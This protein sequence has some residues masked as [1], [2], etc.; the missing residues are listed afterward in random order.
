LDLSK[1]IA[2]FKVIAH[3]GANR[4]ALQNTVAAF[5]AAIDAGADRIEL[6]IHRT[7]D[8]ALVLY[9]DFVIEE[10]RIESTPLKEVQ[11]HKLS[12]G[13]VIATLDEP[14]ALLDRIE[15]NIEIKPKDRRTIEVLAKKM[16]GFDLSKIVFSSFYGETIGFLKEFFP[17]DRIACLWGMEQLDGQ[18][19][20]ISHFSPQ[21]FMQNYGTQIF[22][23][24]AKMVDRPMMEFAQSKNWLVYPWCAMADE[25]EEPEALW[26]ELIEL[27]ADGLCTNEPR[28]LR[29]YLDKITQ[30]NE[31]IAKADIMLPKIEVK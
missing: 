24:W 29:K 21:V 25:K 6:D 22:H 16:K 13:S 3:R 7:S 15:L 1:D 19:H 20:P 23:P 31:L 11:K 30:R 18:E 8:D 9:H 10:K 5:E 26:G 12:D 28:G 2:A 14:L 4:E 17:A 27:G